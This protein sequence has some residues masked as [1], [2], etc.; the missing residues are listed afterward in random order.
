MRKSGFSSLCRPETH[1]K[2][3]QSPQRACT[4]IG[5]SI[6]IQKRTFALN[7]VEHRK[8]VNIANKFEKSIVDLQKSSKTFSITTYKEKSRRRTIIGSKIML[9]WWSSSIDNRKSDI[10]KVQANSKNTLEHTS[11]YSSKRLNVHVGATKW[12]LL[13][14]SGPCRYG[15]K[16]TKQNRTED[17]QFLSIRGQFTFGAKLQTFQ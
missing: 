14:D 10:W 17:F 5:F 4:I 15:E 16:E 13:A 9:H 6:F 1:F 3:A 8:S 2:D 7:R 12:S 11:N